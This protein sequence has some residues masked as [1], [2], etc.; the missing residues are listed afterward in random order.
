MDG[1]MDS[2]VDMRSCTRD[3]MS[4]VSIDRYAAAMFGAITYIAMGGFTTYT[5]FSQYQVGKEERLGLT[6]VCM[7]E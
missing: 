4:F 1:T 2:N 3:E 5:Y 6:Q 7:V